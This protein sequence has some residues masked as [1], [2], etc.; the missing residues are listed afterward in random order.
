MLFQIIK[1]SVFCLRHSG[2]LRPVYVRLAQT[3]STSTCQRLA[4]VLKSGL[5]L[6]NG[7]DSRC[8]QRQDNGHHS[9]YDSKSHLS[10]HVFKLLQAYEAQSMPR[11]IIHLHQ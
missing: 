4:A 1:G 2:L 7:A 5:S 8:H 9:R 11:L 6:L 3:R 10:F